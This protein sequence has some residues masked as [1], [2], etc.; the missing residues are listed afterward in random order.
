MANLDFRPIWGSYRPWAFAGAV[1]PSVRQPFSYVKGDPTSNSYPNGWL[2][3]C[4]NWRRS[5]GAKSSRFARRMSRH[6]ASPLI[7]VAIALTGKSHHDAAQD[8]RLI[9]EQFPEVGAN[10]SHFR[11]QGKG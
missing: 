10:C 7:D 1:A 4:N 11:L 5:R 3:L 2:T 9:L 6:P 8:Y